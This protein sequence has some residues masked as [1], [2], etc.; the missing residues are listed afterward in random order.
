MAP[1]MDPLRPRHRRRR[2]RAM[3]V[4][5][6]VM[7]FAVAAQVTMLVFLALLAAMIGPREFFEILFLM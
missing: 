5:G 4:L 7:I 1:M 3:R 2:T 6:E